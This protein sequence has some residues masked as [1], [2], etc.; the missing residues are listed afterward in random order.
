[1]LGDLS[2]RLIK[3]ADVANDPETIACRQYHTR[4][5]QFSHFQFKSVD[6]NNLTQGKIEQHFSNLKQVFLHNNKAFRLDDLVETLLNQFHI[7][8]EQYGDCVLHKGYIGKVTQA[9]TTSGD[10]GQIMPKK[11]TEKLSL[12]KASKRRTFV[13]ES[14]FKRTKISTFS[15]I[16]FFIV[17]SAKH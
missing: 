11:E 12:D 4:H 7:A 9:H 16:L 1:M 2:W 13:V 15:G 5:K 3:S 10:S 8:Q 6:R 14:K 17:S